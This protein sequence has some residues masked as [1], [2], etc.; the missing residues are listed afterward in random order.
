MTDDA[1]FNRNWA[2]ACWDR[3]TET[4]TAARPVRWLWMM[5]SLAKKK[6]NKGGSSGACPLPLQ[7]LSQL[8]DERKDQLLRGR[9]FYI[10][11]SDGVAWY[12]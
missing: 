11:F 3:W 6:S 10:P 2:G 5:R 4:G 12:L 9:M 8:T 1:F 7:C